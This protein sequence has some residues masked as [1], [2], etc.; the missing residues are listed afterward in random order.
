AAFCLPSEQ[1]AGDFLD[2]VEL[3]EGGIDII[4]G[5]VMGKGLPA[6]LVSAGVKVEMQKARN[7]LMQSSGVPKGLR[8]ADIVTDAH[9]HI[10]HR[11]IDLGSFA[12][13]CYARIDQGEGLLT[14]VDC[15]HPKAIHWS[16]K[17]GKCH[18]IVG[19]N[20][21]LGF[22][23]DEDFTQ[24][25]VQV[26]PG[27]R[28][29]LYSDGISEA[30]NRRGE[31]FGSAPLEK[32]L[33]DR[34][35]LTAE[36]VT[37][38]VKIALKRFAGVSKLSDDCTCV[39]VQMEVAVPLLHRIECEF[40]SELSN[41]EKA[42]ATIRQL[43]EPLPEEEATF[44]HQLELGVTEAISNVMRH[45]YKGNPDYPVVLHGEHYRD[46]VC[47]RIYHWGDSFEPDGRAPTLDMN[48]EGGFGLY[49]LSQIFDNV[50]YSEEKFGRKCIRLEKRKEMLDG[51]QG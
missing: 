42:R 22:L 4:V 46:R 37:K 2:F 36:D 34:S 41:L 23:E 10:S 39:V 50:D 28:L 32:I 3:A 24:V 35:L 16:S 40:T 18:E 8:P 51:S 29:M 48:R 25:T 1:I 27:D 21:P 9:F 30:E 14:I 45:A 12:T 20:I 26:E 7:R 17:T 5:D 15:G 49:L 47:I 33:A 11:L 31:L 38:Q 19:E 43:C 13:A 6:A 44:L